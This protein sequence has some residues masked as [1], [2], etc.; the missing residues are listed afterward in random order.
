ME[1]FKAYGIIQYLQCFLAP[2]LL[3]EESSQ[4]FRTLVFLYPVSLATDS[5]NKIFSQIAKNLPSYITKDLADLWLSSVIDII[6][7]AQTNRNIFRWKLCSVDDVAMS[8]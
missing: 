1:P 5:S 3:K 7:T 6:D 8:K 2:L 4:D